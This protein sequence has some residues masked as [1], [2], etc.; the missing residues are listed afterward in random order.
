M[1][2]QQTVL[3]ISHLSKSFGRHR[4][5]KDVTLEAYAG[6]VLGVLGPNGA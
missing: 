2:E 6:E 1:M 3:K 5:L 4:V